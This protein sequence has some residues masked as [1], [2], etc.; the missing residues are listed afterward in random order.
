MDG[1]MTQEPAKIGGRSLRPRHN[2]RP[3]RYADSGLGSSIGSRSGK[4][5]A[6]ADASDDQCTKLAAASAITR[7][8]AAHSSTIESLPRLSARA[9]RA[10]GGMSAG[11]SSG[12]DED[13]LLQG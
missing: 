2:R 4:N 8:A 12:E 1:V 3:A 13:R 11:A 5:A 7:S 10:N 6:D 9:S